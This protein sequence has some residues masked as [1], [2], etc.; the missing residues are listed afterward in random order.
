MGFIVRYLVT[1]P[2]A[3]LALLLLAGLQAL[4][5]WWFHPSPGMLGVA[6][7]ADIASLSLGVS[8]AVRS[9]AFA[10]Y[11]NRVPLSRKRAEIEGHL[12]ACAEEFQAPARECLRLMDTLG[13]EFSDQ[14]YEAEMGALLGNLSLMA[15]SNAELVRRSRTLGTQEQ[16]Q[17]M[18]D[19][20]GAQV[21][22]IEQMRTSLNRLAGNLALIEASADQQAAS[23]VGLRDVNRGLEELL[24]EWD[25]ES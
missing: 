16:K 15:Q 10:A 8:L 11:V 5:A 2:G 21:K 9:P 19:H 7:L 17:R 18:A 3:W 24:K 13:T 22:T 23:A 14:G 6:A 4:F 20:I 25:H 1:L 12:G